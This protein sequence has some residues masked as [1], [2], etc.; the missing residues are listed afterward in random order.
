MYPPARQAAAQ[1]VIEHGMA[2]CDPPVPGQQ[3]PPG[4]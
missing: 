2:G 1:F 3:F 4:D